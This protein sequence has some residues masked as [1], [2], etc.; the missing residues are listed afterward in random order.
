MAQHYPV[1]DDKILASIN[2]IAPKVYKDIKNNMLMDW[3]Y[4][5]KDIHHLPKEY[6][7]N[8]YAFTIKPYNMAKVW[9][10]EPSAEE[11][12]VL[13]VHLNK[14]GQTIGVYYPL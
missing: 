14:S 7:P 5:R 4:F 8:G 9:K 6:N 1:K 11:E 3:A 12:A 10:D 2:R 13:E